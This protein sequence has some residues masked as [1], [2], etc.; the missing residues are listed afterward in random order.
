MDPI[1]F[2]GQLTE[3]DFRRV[4]SLAGRKVVLGW[5][6]LIA[7]LI[8]V[9]GARWSWEAF[10]ADPV[11][12]VMVFGLLV[13]TIPISLGVR[14]LLLRRHWRSNSLLRQPINGEVSDLGISW[15]IEGVS[16]NQVPWDLLL[17]YRESRSVVLV[18]VGLNQ[19]LYFLPHYFDSSVQW[20]RF[21]G[22]VASKLPRQ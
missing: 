2:A 7:V 12:T 8:I 14:P 4:S 15:V 16:S 20:Q 21:R 18:Y 9:L 1:P 19:F 13:L 17:Q 22:L 3:A 6:A 5:T 11:Y 10:L